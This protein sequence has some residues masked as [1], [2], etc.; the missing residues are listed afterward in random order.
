[1]SHPKKLERA[2][3]PIDFDD[4]FERKTRR[5]LALGIRPDDLL[6]DLTSLPATDIRSEVTP[7]NTGRSPRWAKNEIDVSAILYEDV[8]SGNTHPCR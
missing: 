4:R 3:A 5:T 2:L 1:V 7:E 6:P 8:C